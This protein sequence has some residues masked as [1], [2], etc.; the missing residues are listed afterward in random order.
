MKRTGFKKPTSKKC[1]I[2]K[3][4]F[5][6]PTDKPFAEFCSEECKEAAFVKA[7]DKYKANQERAI[8]K[9][10]RQAKAEVKEMALKN[11]SHGEWEN[12]LETVVREIVRLIDKSWPCIACTRP[13]GGF[14]FHA[15]HRHSVGSNNSIR[16]HLFNIF[17]CCNQCNTHFNGNY[18]GYD[19]GVK[20]TF[21]EDM[22]ENILYTIVRENP[23]V[24]M[25]IPVLQ[26]K[27]V[28]CKEIVK[29]LKA[30][31]TVFSVTQRI[32]LREEYQK[33]IGIYT[34]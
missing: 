24:K 27:I 30:A 20:A 23:F 28:I 17:N 12:N 21:G 19:A 29:E 8:K 32:E 11:K 1:K 15:S 10:V 26:E 7:M 34:I 13:V 6:I 2:C 18:D 3:N 31:D 33:R 4:K 22:L 5:T 9:A 25:S 14:P 16:Y